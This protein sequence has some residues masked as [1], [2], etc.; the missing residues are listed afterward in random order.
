MYKNPEDASVCCPHVARALRD[1]E[2]EGNLRSGRKQN[3]FSR[4]CA[5]LLRLAIYCANPRPK[6]DPQSGSLS[7]RVMGQRIIREYD[8]VTT[9][10]I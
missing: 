8:L 4:V 7:H 2:R 6:P 9:I 5:K 10:L 1:R 3:I